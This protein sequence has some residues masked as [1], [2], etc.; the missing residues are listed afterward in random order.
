[1]FLHAI[2]QQVVGVLNLSLPLLVIATICPV[3]FA[4]QLGIIGCS[5]F[6]GLW[7]YY[8]IFKKAS[9]G[10]QQLLYQPSGQMKERFDRMLT[11]AGIDP[12]TVQLRYSYTNEGL[13]ITTF[14]T[15]CIDP[16]IWKDI[17]D[18]PQAQDCMKVLESY[19]LPTL[20]Q[21]QKNRIKEIKD[22][23]TPGAQKF[24]FMHELAH[25][26]QYYSRK[27]LLLVG[28]IGVFA[29]YAG[30]QSALLL[31]PSFGFGAICMGMVIGG[32][33]DVLFSTYALNLL[34]KAREEYRADYYAA[35]RCSKEELEEA[36]VFWERHQAI[37]D[38]LPDPGLV[39]PAMLISGHNHGN[40][41]AAY[42]RQWAISREKTAS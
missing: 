11:V 25:V 32:I 8:L 30:I 27:S 24:I 41:R 40:K 10:V 22:A 1:M 2:Q 29:A 21:V 16:L 3:I 9:Q 18:D 6:I 26:Q 38:R 34:F 17:E 35:Q 19:I 5:L 39:L 12:Q 33:I 7:V 13:A 20:S 36:A 4:Y 31:A 15:I 37:R 42:L 28:C 23:F 14:N